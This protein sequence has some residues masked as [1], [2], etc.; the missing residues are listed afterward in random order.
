MSKNG[1]LPRA[2]RVEGRVAPRQKWEQR[3]GKSKCSVQ[4]RVEMEVSSFGVEVIVG[5]SS[6]PTSLPPDP[7]RPGWSKVIPVAA[8]SWSGWANEVQGE[9]F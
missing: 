6:W 1:Y 4:A 3:V 8:D 9:F 7:G 2:E 5:P